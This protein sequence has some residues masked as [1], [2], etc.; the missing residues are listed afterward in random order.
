[1]GKN[2]KKER[3]KKE[4][5][6]GRGTQEDHGRT[7]TNAA[8]CQFTTYYMKR[9]SIDRSEEPTTQENDSRRSTNV[10][11]TRWYERPPSVV[12]SASY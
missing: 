7:I 6:R 10:V 9:T 11:A 12:P 3:K 2:G 1:M 5:K 8:R 4:K